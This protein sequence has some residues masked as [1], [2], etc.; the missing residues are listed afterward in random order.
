MILFHYLGFSKFI[1]VSINEYGINTPYT[2][3]LPGFTMQSGLKNTG[4]NWLTLRDKELI[5]I[6]EFNIR[7]GISSV[8][9]NRDVKSDGKKD[10]IFR[11]KWSIQMGYESVF[12]SW[13]NYIRWKC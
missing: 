8:M 3:S 1:N 11:C 12:N 4:K 9:G 13:W 10:N 6:L 5:L 7:G 2:V